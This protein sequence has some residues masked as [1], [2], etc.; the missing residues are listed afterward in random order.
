M[1]YKVQV[2]SISVY[3]LTETELKTVKTT[4]ALTVKRSFATN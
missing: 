3:Y 1:Q 4:V 2:Y